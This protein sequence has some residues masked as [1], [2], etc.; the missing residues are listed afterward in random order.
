VRAN[1][2]PPIALGLLVLA[3]CEQEP[4]EPPPEPLDPIQRTGGLSWLVGDDIAGAVAAAEA[5]GPSGLT[6]ADG[7]S[8]ALD[9]AGDAHTLD[10]LAVAGGLTG[11]RLGL[12]LAGLGPDAPS[13]LCFDPGAPTGDPWLFERAEALSALLDAAPDLAELSIGP[14]L[15]IPP[16]EVACTCTPCDSTGFV[17][18]AARLRATFDLLERPALDRGRE[19]IW[20]DR[21]ARGSTEVDVGVAMDVAIDDQPRGTRVRAATTRG[22]DH[23]WATVSPGLALADE[24]DVSASLDLVASWL[25]PTDAV[26]LLPDRLHDRVRSDRR[27]G[28]VAWYGRT[29]GAERTA[30]SRPEEANLRFAARL[31]SDLGASPEELV[32][33]LVEEEY[34]LTPESEAAAHLVAAL[35]HT[36]RALAMATH[37]L[38]V[39]VADLELGPT[40]LP[41]AYEDP[42]IWTTGWDAPWAT[43]MTPDEQALVD[44]NQWGAEAVDLAEE[45]RESLELASPAMDPADAADLRSRLQVLE[46]AARAWKLTVGADVTLRRYDASPDAELATWLRSDADELDAL[47]DEAET[48]VATGAVADPFPAEPDALR[49]IAAEIRVAVGAGEAVLRPFPVITE[50]GW[51]FEGEQTRIHW[52]VRPEGVGWWER[53]GPG[54]P[55]P[56]EDVS[57]VGESP[58]TFWTGWTTGL[59]SGERVPFRACGRSGDVSVCSSEQVFWRP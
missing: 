26:L 41:L 4:A 25:G 42:R 43:L 13:S 14:G 1:R 53:E 58:A 30:W 8:P 12:Q 24:R 7:Y 55:A 29:T 23:P 32:R 9:G 40:T 22:A 54:W 10:A 51:S 57:A 56:Y 48:A 49:T 50:V 38:G 59:L 6:L 52:T 5:W 44:V 33:D 36:G 45:A 17:G 11:T 20:L 34:G 37:P 27:R 19:A 15:E 35:R 3:A 46:L 28:I 16:W 18:Q 21:I 47:A 39:P 31:Y 2:L